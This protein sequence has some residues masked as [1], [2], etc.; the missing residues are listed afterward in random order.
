MS[1]RRRRGSRGGETAVHSNSK[2]TIPKFWKVIWVIMGVLAFMAITS[3]SGFYAPD[4]YM[5][6]VF[7]LIIILLNI[8]LIYLLWKDKKVEH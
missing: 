4:I 8:Y 6:M 3:F 5:L 1:R 2:K 7:G